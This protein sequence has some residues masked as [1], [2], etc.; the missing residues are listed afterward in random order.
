MTILTPVLQMQTTAA[1]LEGGLWWNPLPKGLSLGSITQLG[2]LFTIQLCT[3]FSFI[4][5]RY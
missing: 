4:N 3:Y 5:Q 2:M 1:Y